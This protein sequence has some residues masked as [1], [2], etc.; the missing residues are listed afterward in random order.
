MLADLGAECEFAD[1]G[2]KGVNKAKTADREIKL[3]VLD[4]RVIGLSIPDII[5]QIRLLP[6]HK[7]VRFCVVLDGAVTKE[8]LIAPAGLGV[9]FFVR[10]EV[11]VEDLVSGFT[12]VF[13]PES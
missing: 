13:S 1:D 9:R 11:S 3:V 2:Q 7:R 6:H 12:K 10:E 8:D 5:N 4:I